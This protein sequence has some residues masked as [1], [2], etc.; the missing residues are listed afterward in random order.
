MYRV[1]EHRRRTWETNWVSRQFLHE[2]HARIVSTA[3]PRG[4][5]DV[6]FENK[7]ISLEECQTLRNYNVAT[8]QCREL[9]SM[10]H[11][12][13]HPQPFIHLRLALIDFSE[14]SWIVD[15]IDQKLPSPAS[16]WQQL[17]PSTDGKLC[18]RNDLY[19]VEW[20]VKLYSLT[21]CD[22]CIRSRCF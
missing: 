18:L 3:V 17:D 8:E 6:L 1:C 21:H 19:C 11:Q 16:R 22:G 20:G 10:L 4:V 2:S 13:Q 5:L 7:V 14:I 15:E 12:S 9:L